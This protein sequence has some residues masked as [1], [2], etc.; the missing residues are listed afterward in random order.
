MKDVYIAELKKFYS[1]SSIVY[2]ISFNIYLGL[3]V[4]VNMID[5]SLQ[6]IPECS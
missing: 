1:I 3:L 5:K 4:W 6:G 2:P